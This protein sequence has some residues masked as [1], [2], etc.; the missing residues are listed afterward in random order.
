MGSRSSRGHRRVALALLLL[1]PACRL[2]FDAIRTGGSW[3]VEGVAELEP[4]RDGRAEVL[5]ALGPPDRVS[6]TL[7]D[8]VFIYRRGGHR[9]TDLRF[10]IPGVAFN[11]LRPG[12]A[13]LS[14]EVEGEEAFEEEALP[15]TATGT[16]IDG[17]FAFMNPLSTEEAL[18]LH[19]R[20]LRW[21]VVRV[22]LDRETHATRGIELFLG[23]GSADAAAL[24][25]E[26]LLLGP[27]DPEQD[28]HRL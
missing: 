21:D 22:V 1:L 6:Y 26:T 7:T 17:L 18:G 15:I 23:I 10:L 28:L 14:P 11:F 5:R 9:G 16:L 25:R 24:W 3:T 8:E 27:G 13:E 19:G 2:H 12:F 20:R 4:G